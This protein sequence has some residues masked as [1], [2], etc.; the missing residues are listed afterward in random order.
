MFID[1]H[2][3]LTF[4]EFDGDRTT[5]IGNAKKAGVKEFIIPG[6]SLESSRK[7][8]AFIQSFKARPQPQAQ[9]EAGPCFASVGCHP[10]ETKNFPDV[11][12]LE[13]MIG[14][15]VVAIGECGLDYHAYKGFPAVG[16]KEEQ[17]QLFEEQ[18][19]LSL[20]H[21]LP[22]I[23]HC[24]DAYPDIF[25]VLDTLPTLPKG[26]FHCFCGGPEDI[27]QVERRGFYFGIDGNV[28]YSKQH[29][30]TVPLIPLSKLLLETD[31]PLLPP[32]PHRGER[33]EPKYI[34]LIAKKIAELKK[35]TVREV[36]NQTT[37]NAKILFG[38]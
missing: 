26:V 33:N 31:S 37:V 22:V 13:K 36:E 16:K 34:P 21:N 38:I 8:V 29:G 30:I 18:L 35:C 6:A 4:P 7:A 19:L 27:K 24:R 14:V 23:I 10:Y 5:V 15:N 9:H 28:T 25:D 20:K 2:C 17:K 12:Q 3:H 1:T 32:I 11:R